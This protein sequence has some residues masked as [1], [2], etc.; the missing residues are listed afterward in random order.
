MFFCQKEYG[1]RL[2][3]RLIVCLLVILMCILPSPG[4]FAQE[5]GVQKAAEPLLINSQPITAGAVMREYS[6]DVTGGPAKV[7]VT[8]V[9]LKNPYIKV[10]SIPGGGKITQRLNVSAMAR[11]AGAVAAVNGD[12][13]NTQGEGAPIGPMVTA[14]RFVS[15]PSVLTGTYALG[16]TADRKAYIDSFSF[17]GKVKAP[18]GQ[19][20]AL[21][22]LN[23]TIYW[24]EPY[25]IHSHVDKLHLYNDM[26][27][28]KTR[29]HDSYSTPTE[30][31]ISGGTIV[32]IIQ[33]QYFDYPVPEGMLILRG[34]GRA[35]GFLMDNF[36]VGDAIE[37]VYTHAP[38][39]DWSMIVGGHA[40][41]VD[42]G[43]AVPYTKDIS[44]LGGIRART[45]AGVSQDGT[46]L[47][48][49]SVEGRTANSNGLSLSNLSAFFEMLGVWRAVNLD[50]GGSTTLVSRPLGDFNATRVFMPEQANERLVVNAIGIFSN[51]PKGKLQGFVLDGQAVLLIGEEA[52]Y[53]V[54][55]YDDYFNPI[56]TAALKFSWSIGGPAGNI[57]EDRFKAELPGLYEILV[58]SDMVIT[59]LPVEVVGKREVKALTLSGNPGQIVQGSTVSLSLTLNTISGKSRKV[60][61]N[62][63][64]WQF[65]GI[66][67][68]VSPEGLVTIQDTGQAGY[69][70]LVARYQGFSAPLVIQ[71][72]SSPVLPHEP[73]RTLI[74]TVGE[75]ELRIDGSVSEMD[76]APVIIDGRTLVPV[77]F[78]SE[79]LDAQVLWDGETKNA[80][81]IQGKRWINLW[82]GDDLMVVDGKRVD[83]DV[84]PQ[85]INGRT[86]LPLRAVSQ[87][88]D[89]NV[90]WDSGTRQ[91]TLTK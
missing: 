70:F 86:M 65:Y 25:G 72:D 56:D 3:A 32:D 8:E 16:V 57:Q 51:A 17:D 4:V 12:F 64:D 34:H 47:Y 14:G 76:V 77:R 78:I 54:K 45:A 91:I 39:R 62:L 83:L 15:S 29:G 10:D 90:H 13:F 82:P 7:Y 55:A 21:S 6:W 19:E 68:S 58:K 41:L 87:A 1:I 35:A 28:G 30:V 40:L 66:E 85:I 11:N 69:G 26:W 80:T 71:I 88:L 18:N 59:K 48:L 67:G 38:E 9:D 5:N 33:G 74:L 22:G 75:K 61:A 60:P 89:L 37:I 53:S 52:V 43:K 42:Q 50:G 36:N 31:L 63:V 20:F 24:E 79:A 73:S 84:A 27:G 44:A 46:T 49:V 2:K 23:K 81:V